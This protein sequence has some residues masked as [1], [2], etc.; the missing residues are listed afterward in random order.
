M[1]KIKKTKIKTALKK[2]QKKT[3]KARKPSRLRVASRIKKPALSRKIK[4]TLRMQTKSEIIAKPKFIP[5][6]GYLVPLNPLP[7]RLAA[8][9]K[10]KLMHNKN[11]QPSRHVLNL[12][13]LAPQD[14]KDEAIDQDNYE[15][16]I[17]KFAGKKNFKANFIRKV[18]QIQQTITTPKNKSARTPLEKKISG[19]IILPPRELVTPDLTLKSSQET[20]TFNK[21]LPLRWPKAILAFVIFCLVIV[22]P[23]HI[24][25]YYQTLQGKKSDVLEQ[26]SQALMHLAT[27]QKAAS[28]KDAYYTGM[29]LQQ[30][31]ANFYQ[32]KSDLDDINVLIKG[33]IK[34][35]PELDKELTTANNLADAGEKL[36]SSAALLASAVDEIKINKSVDKLNLTDNLAVLK[37]KLN[38]ILPDLE[39]AN[40]D[41]NNVALEK[42]PENYRDKVITLQEALPLIISNID[43]FINS[44]DLLLKTLGQNTSQRYMIL[45]QNNN[46]LRPTGG[47][48][49]SYAIVEIDKGNIVKI[50]VPGGGPYDLKG[51]LKA[52]IES[53]I[54]LHLVNTRWE[55]QDGNWYPNLPTSA[56]KLTYLYQKS[57][58]PTVDGII[59]INATLM[60]KILTITG[61]IDLPEYNLTLDADNFIYQIQK[62]VE[63]DYNKEENRPKE[64]IN[65]LI[66]QLFTKLTNSDSEQFFSLLDLFISSLNEKEIQFYFTDPE[67]QRFINKNNWGGRIKDTT[68]DYLNIIS[69]NIAGEKTDAKIEQTAFLDVNVQ[70]DGSIIN[71]LT[72]TKKHNGTEG[73]LFYG[74]PNLDFMRI[75]VPNGSQLLSAQGFETIPS[76]FFLVTN[77]A[78]YEKDPDI[79]QQEVTK[80]ID[81]QSGTEIYSEENKTV[82]ANWFKVNPQESKTASIEYQLPIKLDLTNNTPSNIL[83]I[84]ARQLNFNRDDVLSEKTY[85]LLW[86]KQ[87]GKRNFNIHV[88]VHFPLELKAKFIYPNYIQKDL[89][90]F[91]LTDE[92][93]IDK[94]MAINYNE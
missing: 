33:L 60:Q 51:Q 53:P 10:P 37:D 75:Y 58:G 82:F 79:S 8:P 85:S 56:E 71:K 54:P 70:P 59:F 74:V 88:S 91:T 46:E 20:R 34:L 12:K 50:D 83:E 47:F 2:A 55:F 62:N 11:G 87:S 78:V 16:L 52:T 26:A 68:G 35:S 64:I 7:Q 27:S 18:S 13:K 14:I 89:Q 94:F 36:A 61:S 44:S 69:T 65:D 41:L 31:A 81:G 86:Q 21:Y 25:N 92:L 45:F 84:I 43:N 29:E 24:Y 40:E 57:S 30:S 22:A 93:N 66:P 39:A 49:G 4:R 15:H 19:P 9:P 42:L 23:F 6:P 67:M 48:I 28:A 80:N 72:I 38:L 17:N 90:T 73:E 32:A 63:L 5:K 1:P 76:E 3:M 77:H